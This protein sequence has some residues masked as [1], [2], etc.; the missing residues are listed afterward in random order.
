MFL[1]SFDISGYGLS[2]QRLRVNLI[3]SNIANA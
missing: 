1:S 2:A 3:S